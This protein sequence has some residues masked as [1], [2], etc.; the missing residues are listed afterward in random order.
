MGFLSVIVAALAAFFVGAVWYGVFSKPW[1]EASGVELGADDKPVNAGN[2]MTYVTALIF[3]I[4]V[5]GMMRHIFAL[6]GIDTVDK[7]LVSGLGIGLFLIAPWMGIHY[8]F[9]VKPMKLLV[10][11]GGY[12]A[13][14]CA[15][16]GAVL[17]LF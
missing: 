3:T 17:T 5:A 2:P 9:S 8:T 4:L 6:S 12:A 15:V 1:K 14:G 13:V 16:M 10:I 7:G 11:D